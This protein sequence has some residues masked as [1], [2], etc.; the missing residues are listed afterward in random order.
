MPSFEKAQK[1][2]RGANS[3]GKL[4][5]KKASQVVEPRCSVCQHG[6]RTVI[7]KYLIKGTAYAEIGRVFGLDRRSVSNHYKSHLNLEDAAMARLIEHEAA[8]IG[9]DFEEG[10]RGILARRVYLESA[11]KK[12]QEALVNND[13]TVEPKDAV[14]IIEKLDKMEQETNEAAIIQM[15]IELA[16][17]IQAM[18]EIVP[19]DLWDQIFTR[20]KA[21]I[22]RAAV[23]SGEI[24]PGD[25]N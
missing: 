22:D 21:L 7:D 3:N 12:A 9:E 5:S 23:V 8:E 14:A 19:S 20:T 13:V 16:A 25:N 18:K 15:R 4:P 10:I 24:G 2:A 11:L 17:Y 6:Q 1:N